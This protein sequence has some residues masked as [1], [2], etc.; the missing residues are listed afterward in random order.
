[1]TV[2]FYECAQKKNAVLTTKKLLKS[3]NNE[4]TR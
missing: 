1:M 3:F 2:I 4:Q